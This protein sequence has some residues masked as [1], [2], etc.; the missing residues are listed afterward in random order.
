MIDFSLSEEERPSATRSGSS[1]SRRS[2]RSRTRCCATSAAGCLARARPAG[3][4][5]AQGEG[6][7][8]VGHQH[9]R[10]VRRHRPRPGDVRDRGDGD[11]P[12]LRPVPVR[13]L[14]RQHPLRR[15]RRAEAAVPHPH[16][17]RRAPQLFAITEPGGGLRRP[18]HQDPGGQGRRRLGDQQREDVHHRR[19]RG[20]LRHGLRR[21]RPGQRRRRRRD[22]L[23]GRPR[24]GLEVGADPD[25]GG[26]GARLAGVRGRPRPRAATSSASSATV[27][28]PCSGSATA[29][30]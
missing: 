5:A 12:D 14:G 11:R 3:G 4:A 15:H 18:Q 9:A 2:C 26:V 8:L 20:R 28:S 25:D 30:T 7:R 29:A 17:Q 16:H 10:A 27:H 19:Q 22:L 23:P 6:R 13:R 21:H 24:H 1:S